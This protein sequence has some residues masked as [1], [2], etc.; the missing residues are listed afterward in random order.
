MLQLPVDLVDLSG[1]AKIFCESFKFLKYVCRKQWLTWVTCLSLA[2]N[3]CESF[4]FGKYV[5]CKQW[6]TWVTC[7]V[8]QNFSARGSFSEIMYV[9]N[10][11]WLGWLVKARKNFLQEAQFLKICVSHMSGWLGWLARIIFLQAAFFQIVCVAN[12]V[13]MVDLPYCGNY[14]FEG[15]LSK[16][17]TL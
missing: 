4:I 11:G 8:S 13:E 1:L 14:F 6:L 12:A 16:T 9:V 3:F 7:W 2:K 5:C 10:S 15:A 17:Y